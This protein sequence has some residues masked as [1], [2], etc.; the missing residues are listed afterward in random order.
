MSEKILIIKLSALGDFIQALGP[1]RAIRRHHADAH[2]TLLTT[3]PLLSFAKACG[4]FDKIVIDQRP[5]FYDLYGWLNLKRFFKDGK[6]TRIYDLQ[7]S[8]RSNAYFRLLS[9]TKRPEWVGTAKGASHQNTSQSRTA[10]HAFDGHVQTLSLAGIG[11]VET[12]DLSWINEDVSRFDIAKPYILIVAGSAPQHPQ[13]RWPAPHYS[14]LAKSINKLGITPVLLGT[15]SESAVTSN[16]KSECPDAIDLTG[17]TSLFEIAVLAR[18]A[19]A[20]IGNDT[21]P[22]HLIAPTGC[23]CLTLFSGHSNPKR[24]YPKGPNVQILQRENLA[25][26]S[27]DEV[28]TALNGILKS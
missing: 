5:K 9:K 28:M 7:N 8:D 12:D 25:D 16:I 4:Y 27:P 10:G 26:L 1:M 11:Q 18:D 14:T 2:I 15:M 3:T 6:F 22:M 21:G 24:H 23:P 13:K 19:K 17:Q 20:A